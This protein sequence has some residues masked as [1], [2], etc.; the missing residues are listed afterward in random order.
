MGLMTPK[1]VITGAH[2]Q[3]IN[4][5]LVSW[6]LVDAAGY[7]SDQLPLKDDTQGQDGLPQEGAVIGL[8]VGYVESDMY[9]K[10]EFKITRVTPRLFPSLVTIVATAAPF[11]AT[12]ESEFKARKSASFEQ[13]TLGAIFEEIASRHGF[14]PRIDPQLSAIFIDHVDQT[15]ETDMSFLTRLANKHDAV[16]KPVNDLLVMAKRGQVKTLS[17]QDLP[18]VRLTVPTNQNQRSGAFLNA[19]ADFP[20]KVRFKGVV[21]NYWNADTGE[22]TEVRL[23]EAPFKKLSQQFES[24]SQA[25]EQAE[26]ELQKLSRIGMKIRLDVPGDPLLA[27]EG[28][29]E[30][31]ET[32]PSY[33]TGTWSID[34]VISR[35]DGQQ[36]YRCS[37]EATAPVR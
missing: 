37:I 29:L 3:L 17:G 32:W 8:Q 35:S 2:A 5:R 36:S 20:S 4:Q 34:R 16:A 14:S 31:D 15:D 27:A 25:Q 9:D 21:A 10:G 13:T 12:D 6:E 22:E 18:P 30:L 33:M 26:A 1:V 24:E 7:Q 19:E 23:G 11:T 28:L